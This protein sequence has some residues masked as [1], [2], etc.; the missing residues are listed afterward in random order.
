MRV[1]A[2]SGHP[3]LKSHACLSPRRGESAIAL[4]AAKEALL[5]LP[6]SG[7]K[8]PSRCQRQKKHSCLSPR[9]GKVP[10]RCQWQ[11]KHSCLSPR[12]GKVPSRC[13][14]QKKH[15]CLSPRRGEVSRSDGE[16]P[17]LTEG[18]SPDP[19]RLSPL[20]LFRVS[21]PLAFGVGKTR[22]ALQAEPR[23]YFPLDICRNSHYNK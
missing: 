15:S 21:P 9:R 19:Q 18:L 2:I 13:Q 11:K 22:N 5:P 17:L 20:R 7:G 6:A 10:S 12:R 14:R 3:V 23:G 16:G 4:P 1:K 8:V